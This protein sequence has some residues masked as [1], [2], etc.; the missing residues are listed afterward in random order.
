M[1]W[2][3]NQKENLLRASRWALT[4][5]QDLSGQVPVLSAEQYV[6][7]AKSDLLG[8]SFI[9]IIPRKH[10]A[11]GGPLHQEFEFLKG[12]GKIAD[13]AEWDRIRSCFEP[14]IV[15]EVLSA[16]ERYRLYAYDHGDHEG[17]RHELP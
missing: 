3:R 14:S 9:P 12:L 7:L 1:K 4:A 5:G 16:G 15:E 10:L 13:T 17:E 8:I 2:L 11:D 6:A